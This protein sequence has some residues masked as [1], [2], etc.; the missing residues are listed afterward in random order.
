V[1]LLN[2]ALRGLTAADALHG[3]G[4]A[5]AYRYDSSFSPALEWGRRN[6]V[7]EEGEKH[8]AGIPRELTEAGAALAKSGNEELS[9]EALE[10]PQKKLVAAAEAA[11]VSTTG[12]RGARTPSV[13]VVGRIAGVHNLVKGSTNGARIPPAFRNQTIPSAPPADVQI[14]TGR[15]G[16]RACFRTT[17]RC[18]AI[19]TRPRRV[20]VIAFLLP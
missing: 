5:G 16:F 20:H 15:G 7:R 18:R 10:W 13:L 1:A 14:V 19:T 6:P 17:C 12:Q 9:A 11:M 3:E 2:Q 8:L 4:G